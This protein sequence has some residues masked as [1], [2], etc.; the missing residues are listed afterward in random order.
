M[1]VKK[2]KELSK[3][4]Q[5]ELALAQLTKKRHEQ[6]IKTYKK[7]ETEGEDNESTTVGQSQAKTPVSKKPRTGG[8]PN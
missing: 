3:I 6:Q 2:L 8:K 1:E 4:R 7:A 5:N